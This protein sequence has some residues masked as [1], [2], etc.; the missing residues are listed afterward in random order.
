MAKRKSYESKKRSYESKKYGY[1]NKKQKTKKYIAGNSSPDIFAEYS[2][3]PA[4]YSSPE[5]PENSRRDKCISTIPEHI[6]ESVYPLIRKTIPNHRYSNAQINDILKVKFQLLCNITNGIVPHEKMVANINIAKTLTGHPNVVLSIMQY[7]ATIMNINVTAPIKYTFPTT[8]IKED[9]DTRIQNALNTIENTNKITIVPVFLPEH[10]NIVIIHSSNEMHII[11]LFEPNGYIPSTETK[12]LYE[13]IKYDCKKLAR[14]IY[15]DIHT[16]QFIKP[17]RCR[18]GKCQSRISKHDTLECE[19]YRETCSVFSLW[20]MF[21]RII[22]LDSETAEETIDNMDAILVDKTP[23]YIMELIYAFIDVLSS[24]INDLLIIALQSVRFTVDGYKKYIKYAK[25]QLTKDTMSIIYN[26]V[27]SNNNAQY[28]EQ[29][30]KEE[31]MWNSNYLTDDII[32]SA[33]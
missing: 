25:P 19:S 22:Y 30:L 13:L 14:V 5:P 28:L 32:N 26:T 15:P 31:D 6:P 1:K 3:S 23:N 21:N 16:S 8:D 4:E 24:D 2:S 12:T 29:A 27:K 20:Y 9:R 33:H 17:T 10:M 18:A 11:E 7:I